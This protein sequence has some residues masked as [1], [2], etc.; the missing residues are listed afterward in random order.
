MCRA[1]F[2][3]LFQEVTLNT[4][5][6]LL[7]NLQIFL[8][9]NQILNIFNVKINQYICNLVPPPPPPPPPAIP[10]IYFENLSKLIQLNNHSFK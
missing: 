5:N 2:M 6:E 1:Q 8:R 9:N 10:G 4:K 7:I 3:E